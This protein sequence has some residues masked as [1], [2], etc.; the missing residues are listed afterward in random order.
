VLE[1]EQLS[2]VKPFAALVDLR[3]PGGPD[4]E[5]LR[6]LRARFPDIPLFVIT[7]YPELAPLEEVAGT[8]SK[9]FDTA[10]LVQALEG[11]HAAR[12]DAA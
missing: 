1:T 6:R 12:P 11:A 5:A 7:A 8:F 2:M 3:L 4:G 9:P 10:A